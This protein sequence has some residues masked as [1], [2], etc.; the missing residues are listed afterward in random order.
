MKF[1]DKYISETEKLLEPEDKRVVLSNDAFAI[2]E[3]IERLIN[4]INVNK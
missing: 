1:E 2:G 4:V 3:I